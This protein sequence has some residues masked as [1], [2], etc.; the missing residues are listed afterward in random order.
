MMPAALVF[1]R[2]VPASVEAL[3]LFGPVT[4]FSLQRP[5]LPL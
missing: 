3:F 5:H 4:Q 2:S 1:K